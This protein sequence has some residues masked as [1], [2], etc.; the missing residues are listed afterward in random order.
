MIAWKKMMLVVGSAALAACRVD[1]AV[2]VGGEV[3]TESGHYACGEAQ[4]CTIDVEDTAFDETFVAVPGSG[5]L[6]AG[7]ARGERGLCGGSLV[8]CRLDASLMAAHPTLMQLL[9]SDAVFDLQPQF[10]PEQQL[11]QYQP[12]DVVRFSGTLVSVEAGK[13]VRQSVSARLAFAASDRVSDRGPLL[14]A[15]L[16]LADADGEPLQ[17]TTRFFTQSDAGALYQ[18]TD[19]YG[20]ELYDMAAAASGLLAIPVPLVEFASME[21]P[22]AVMWGGHTSGPVALG[23][24]GISVGQVTEIESAWGTT[25]VYPVSINDVY[26][27]TTTYDVF[28]KGHAV[29]SDQVLW[30]SQVKGLVGLRVAES[31]FDA[32]DRLLRSMTLELD[33]VGS[34]F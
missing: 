7:W 3:V 32:N 23:D 18:Y 11:R 33:A 20:N 1:I 22:F 16:T 12:G 6:F 2:P 15:T 14:S 8:P 17:S 26:A 28:K 27:Y 19:R 30:V 10:L 29:T 34:N 31:V 13:G 25:A 5:Q 24:R 9:E 21:I 4:S